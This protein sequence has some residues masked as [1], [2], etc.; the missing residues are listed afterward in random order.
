MQ[1][2]VSRYAHTYIILSPSTNNKQ[3]VPVES[4][5]WL[6]QHILTYLYGNVSMYRIANIAGP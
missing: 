2:P 1:A 5:I 6:Y 3:I 4:M